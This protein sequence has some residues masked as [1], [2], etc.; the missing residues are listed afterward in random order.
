MEVFADP[1]DLLERRAPKENALLKNIVGYVHQPP[2]VEGLCIREAASGVTGFV[3]QVPLAVGRG[4]FGMSLES[5]DGAAHSARQ[6]RVVGVE[7]GHDFGARAPEA[8]VDGVRLAA[9]F[10]GD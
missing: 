9:I 8:L 2:Q 6:E 1:A 7:P 3:G 10:L 4:C 5:P